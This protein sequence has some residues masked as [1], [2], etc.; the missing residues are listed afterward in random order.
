MTVVCP[1]CE[2]EL[3][4]QAE[5]L[6]PVSMTSSIAGVLPLLST[7]DKSDIAT[8]SSLV[9]RDGKHHLVFESVVKCPHCNQEFCLDIWLPTSI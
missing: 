8:Y 7:K 9:Y 3:T 1:N 4:E 2:K 6:I 5:V